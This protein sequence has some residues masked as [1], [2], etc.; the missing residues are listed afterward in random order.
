MSLKKI[1]NT[2]NE[3][4]DVEMIKILTQLI[5]PQS[6]HYITPRSIMGFTCWE[7]LKKKYRIIA[8][9]HCMICNRYVSHTPDDWL[10]L[11]ESYEYD[12]ENRIQ[13]LVGYVSI[14]HE[15]HMYIHQ[16][17]LQIQLTNGDI[18]YEQYEKILNKGDSLLNKYH[19]EKEVDPGDGENWR[20]SYQGKLYQAGEEEGV[21][22]KE[23]V[24][25]SQSIRASH[26]LWQDERCPY[27]GGQVIQTDNYDL[28]DRFYVDRFT[29]DTPYFNICTNCGAGT[30]LFMENGELRAGILADEQINLGRH[31]CFELF[32]QSWLKN[33]N[34]R[35]INKNYYRNQVKLAKLMKISIEACNFYY[36]NLEDLRRAYKFMQTENWWRQEAYGISRIFVND[37][38][39][40]ERVIFN[41][42]TSIDTPGITGDNPGIPRAY[43]YLLNKELYK[44]AKNHDGK[45]LSEYIWNSNSLANADE[46]R[47]ALEERGVY[48]E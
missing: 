5:V 37:D 42:S 28:R 44:M 33:I 22:F 7:D 10:E 12:Y 19:L 20:L 30:P 27:C 6:L 21:P 8:N 40:I 25:I 17:L 11:H 14:C 36:F 48:I 26:N 2:I 16:G 38:N 46:V 4:L 43:V 3:D 24:D 41:D 31:Y 35:V 1:D 29:I 9:H 32:N 18:S 23:E 45:K 34:G 13:K 15:C 39:Q 47:T